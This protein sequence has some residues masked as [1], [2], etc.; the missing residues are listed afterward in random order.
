[1]I[2]FRIAAL[3]LPLAAAFLAPALLAW[4]PGW[5]AATIGH[6]ALCAPVILLGLISGA[7]LA[8]LLGVVVLATAFTL[9]A[10]GIHLAMGQVAA[11]VAACLLTASVFFAPQAVDDAIEKKQV[12][13]IPSRIN[14]CFSV[15]PW[16]GMASS[17]LGMD[18]LHDF[19][20]LYR[21]HLADYAGVRIPG[22]TGL[23]AGYALIGVVVGGAGLA[24]RRRFR[25]SPA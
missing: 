15:S 24:L 12:A 2:A 17:P 11:G 3:A 21:A 25:R 18:V 13:A 14:L 9:L 16:A 10:S 8:T 7:G 22:W 1:V 4:R 5:K 6:A 20:S 23:A 19:R